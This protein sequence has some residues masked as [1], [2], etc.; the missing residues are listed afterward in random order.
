MQAV[1]YTRVC[2]RARAL[3][4]TIVCKDTTHTHA[5]THDA[6]GQMRA[7]VAGPSAT[8]RCRRRRRRALQ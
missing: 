3:S 8:H 5:G 2:A 1:L 6:R 4:L 7:L